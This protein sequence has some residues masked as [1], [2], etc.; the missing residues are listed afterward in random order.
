MTTEDFSAGPIEDLRWTD[1]IKAS[2]V[3]PGYRPRVHGYDVRGEMLGKVPFSALIYLSLTGELPSK[4][5]LKAF[6]IIMAFISPVSVA[7][8]PGHAAHLSGLC[9]TGHSGM[10]GVAAVSLSE[11]ARNI[12]EEHRELL[13]CVASGVEPPPDSHPAENE[14]ARAD[15]LFLTGALE[16]AGLSVP[17]FVSSLAPVSAALAS[18]SLFCGFTGHAALETVLL[19]ARLPLTL[20]EGRAVKP[21]N[22]RIY[23][24]DLPEY[25][26]HHEKQ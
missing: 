7:E 26:Y 23:P 18:L 21:G 1:T 5:V 25:R 13:A 16:E 19:L 8:A 15:T 11:Q 22:F 9:G 3:T 12:I 4:P 6:D 24:I 2:V 17:E 14:E 20:A 10:A